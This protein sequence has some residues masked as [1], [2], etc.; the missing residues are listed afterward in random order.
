MG[1]FVSGW[2]GNVASARLDLISL[3]ADRDKS[4]HARGAFR[5]RDA[6]ARS[7]DS[8]KVCAQLGMKRR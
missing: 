8:A 1:A 7:G 6:L 2:T 5:V 4:H 3:K